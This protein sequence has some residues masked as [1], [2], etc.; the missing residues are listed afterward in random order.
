MSFQKNGKRVVTIILCISLTLMLSLAFVSDL[1][2]PR[3][4]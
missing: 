2:D 3:A 1:A 4:P